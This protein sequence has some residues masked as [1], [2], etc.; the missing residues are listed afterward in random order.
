MLAEHVSIIWELSHMLPERDSP[1]AHDVI[2]NNYLNLDLIKGLNNDAINI[3]IPGRIS[4]DH[5]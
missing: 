2:G 1:L 5:R 4:A 3:A